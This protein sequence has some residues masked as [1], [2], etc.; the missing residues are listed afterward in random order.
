MWNTLTTLKKQNDGRIGTAPDYFRCFLPVFVPYALWVPRG[1]GVSCYFRQKSV[2]RR[3]MIRRIKIMKEK[4]NATGDGKYRYPG[5]C[6]TP[7]SIAPI[8]GIIMCHTTE[9]LIHRLFQFLQTVRAFGR[10]CPTRN[11]V[12][13]LF[14]ENLV[15]V[16]I[17]LEC[18]YIR[19]RLP[20]HVLVYTQRS[21]SKVTRSRKQS[22][23]LL[24]EVL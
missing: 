16:F 20:C 12:R 6:C 2:A 15:N 23:V 7:Q 5:R 13:I 17:V 10:L 22:R 3:L 24:K 1:S 9:I 21:D 14:Q 18:E 4:R 8:A 11:R 19:L